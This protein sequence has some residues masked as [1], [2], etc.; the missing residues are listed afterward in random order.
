MIE[1][2]K[3]FAKEVMTAA[4]VPTAAA[5]DV[6][7]RGGGGG[8]LDA[9]GPPYV[10]KADGLAAGKGVVVDRRPAPTRWPHAAGRGTVVIE[11][12]LDGPEVSLF[13]ICAGAARRRCC[14]P[15]DYKP[16]GDGNTGPNTGG[17]GRLRAAALGRRRPIASSTRCTARASAEMAARGTAYAGVLYAG[18]S[19]DP[20]GPRVLEFNVRFGDPETQ[21]VLDRLDT[22]LAGLL[23]AAATG[24][25]AAAGKLT[26]T[27]GA[28][29]TVV[30]A[31]EGYPAP[32][33][34]DGSRAMIP[35]GGLTRPASRFPGG[36]AYVLHAGTAR[37]NGAGA[38]AGRGAWGPRVGRRPGAQCRRHRPG[39][40][41]RA[42][43][44]LPA[45]A[46]VGM[47]GGW[48]RCDIATAGDRRARAA[49]PDAPGRDRGAVAL[50]PRRSG[51]TVSVAAEMA[52]LI[53]IVA[54][55]D[56]GTTREPVTMVGAVIERYT[57]PEM[58]RV[59]SEA[60][61]YEL[62]CQVET[63]VLAGAREGGHGAGGQ[64]GAGARR[65]AADP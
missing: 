18:L 10:V 59:W 46:T 24:D 16:H 48:Y 14:P 23:A 5:A 44:G 4:G 21:V 54:V 33:Q 7:H 32:G 61:K 28:A 41:G 63:L 17:M 65:A 26:W 31:A 56:A 8:A 25:L 29:V 62:W 60:H 45:A 52:L 6:R 9:F 36:Q 39:P 11:E 2:R 15:Q 43:R 50:P 35:N 38:G 53:V 27:P 47:R 22:P 57:L 19:A 12:G 49:A 64:R 51:V 20:R 55:A 1:G 34:G 58:G 37:R 42:G 40:G 13:A 3:S 30:L